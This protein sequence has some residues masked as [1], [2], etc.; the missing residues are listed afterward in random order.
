M[1]E[2]KTSWIIQLIDRITGPMRQVNNSSEDYHETI[3]SITHSL[4]KMDAAG[5]ETAQ[6]AINDHKNLTSE[7]EKESQK[8][9]NLKKRL[10]EIPDD[11]LATGPVEFDIKNAETKIRRYKEQLVEIEHEL[12]EISKKPDAEKVGMNWRDITL[13]TNQAAE[14]AQ[15]FGDSM[16]FAQE[17]K[18]LQRNVQLM[19]GTSGE[20][21]EDLTHRS[22]K[23]G[24]EFGNDGQEVAA[25]AN[26]MSKQM[27][28]SMTAAFD[29]IEAGYLKGANLN[30]D[31]LEQLKEYSGQLSQ[32]GIS[33]SEA[34][35]LMAQAGKQ[36]IFSDKA[37]DSI[38]EANMSLREMGPAQIEALKGIGLKAKDFAGKTSMEAMQMI[39]A[40]MDG[41]SIQAKQLVIAD[42]FKGA[43][44]DAGLSWV[45][46]FSKM[47]MDVNNMP[48]V[49]RAGT[50][51]RSLL[52]DMELWFS[53]SMGNV[54]I[55]LQQLSGP[56][57]TVAGF[58][59]IFQ[60]LGKVQWIASLGTKAMAAA[61]WL[62]N[63]AM[64]ANPIGI[65]IVAVGALIAAI[66]WAY[67]EFEGFRAVIDG[68]WET[69]KLVFDN[70]Y[71]YIMLL[72][73]P[74]RLAFGFLTGGVAGF[75]EA[76]AAIK[77]DAVKMMD[78]TVKIASGQAFKE[79]YNNSLAESEKDKQAEADAEKQKLAGVDAS[80]GNK[81]K[82]DG[83]ITDPN[84]LKSQGMSISGSGGS[85][86][87][88]MRVEV[89]NYFNNIKSDLDIQQAADKIAGMIN[90]RLKDTLVMA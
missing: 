13:L 10:S 54:A 77:A 83:K 82:L 40:A 28:I 8:V 62:L 85:K 63:A 86:A 21:L 27:G 22:Y 80:V 15:K 61:Q 6:Q 55:T 57:Q 11:P 39:S 33:G 52:T 20:A 50:G 48:N 68:L 19:T 64:T 32:S 9:D 16:E 72:L 14:A 84:A 26:A 43:G 44:E 36:G 29:L 49:E 31:M 45:E 73:A 47:D 12:D 30:G 5:K 89:K 24:K 79:G 37:I 42:I 75:K 4:D 41:K 59:P 38:K 70:I 1:A 25:A 66:V 78:N 3:K 88:S 65:I 74:I 56:V 87:I 7:I 2:N 53:D 46:G 51:I 60:A 34:I 17:I 81:Q 90:D 35:A 23:L 76:Q 71:R 69:F 67:N 18:D 58:I